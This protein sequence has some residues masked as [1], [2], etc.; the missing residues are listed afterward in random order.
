MSSVNAPRKGPGLPG[1]PGNPWVRAGLYFFCPLGEDLEEMGGGC[2]APAR[3]L[4]PRGDKGA[5]YTKRANKKK[6]TKYP[7]GAQ[8]RLHEMRKQKEGAPDACPAPPG[9]GYLSG[10]RPA[11]SR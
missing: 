4:P 2:P 10:Q 1:A 9:A 3:P 8:G 11:F 7:V 6:G 5:D